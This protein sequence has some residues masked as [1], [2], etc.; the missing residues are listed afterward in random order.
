MNLYVHVKDSLE[1]VYRCTNR[2]LPNGN[3]TFI[4]NFGTLFP[5][6]KL[7][8]IMG[9]YTID[10]NADYL[11]VI[12][13]TRDT[14]NINTFHLM[15]T[16]NANGS[17]VVWQECS[18]P[19]NDGTYV[20]GLTIDNHNPSIVYLTYGNPKNDLGEPMEGL[21]Y[22]LDYTASVSNPVVTDLTKNLPYTYI[23][24]NS[25]T[26]EKSLNNG[27]YLATEFGVFYTDDILLAETDWSWKLVGKNLPHTG[28]NGIEINY[29]SNTIRVGTWGRGVWDIPLPCLTTPTSLQI[30]TNTII[31]SDIR[32]DRDIIVKSGKTLTIT[33][34]AHVY[35]PESGKIIVEPG[36]KLYV[37]NGTITSGCQGMWE[38]VQVWG[39]SNNHQWPDSHGNF[40]QGYVS[41]EDAT[42]SNAKFALNLYN[43]A[44]RAS[45]GGIVIANNSHFL[46]N[47]QSVHILNYRNF[48]PVTGVEMDYQAIFSNCD[49]RI[50]GEYWGTYEFFKHVDL[51]NVRGIKFKGSDFY[52]DPEATNVNKF[53]HGIAAYSAGFT[54]GPMCAS[55]IDP[56]PAYDKCTFSGLRSGITVRNTNSTNTFAVSESIF[57]NLVYGI[58]NYSANNATIVNN[59]FNIGSSYCEDQCAFGIYQR[60]AHGFGIENNTFSLYQN[61]NCIDHYGIC[62]MNTNAIDEIYHN[63]FTNLKYANF[64]QGKNHRL[65]QNNEG[66]KYFCN[67]NKSNYADFYVQPNL[68]SAVQYSQ[69]SPILP[70]GNTFSRAAVYHLYSGLSHMA[71]YYYMNP[72][73]TPDT[74]KINQ[75]VV[76]IPVSVANQCANHYGGTIKDVRLTPSEEELTEIDYADALYNFNQINTLYNSLIAG[77]STDTKLTEVNTATLDDAW[78][79]RTNLLGTSPHLSETVLKAM[80]DRTDILSDQTMFEILSANPDELRNNELMKYLEEKSTPLPQFMIDILKQMSSGISYRTTLEMNLAYYE[81]LKTRAANDMIRSLL[82]EE[83]IDYNELRNWL[84][85]LGGIEADR[86]IISTYVQEKN[87]PEAITLANLLP[88]L[89]NFSTEEQEVYDDYLYMLNLQQT[90]HQQDRTIEELTEVELS[91]VQSISS[92]IEELGGIQAK[93]VMEAVFDDWFWNCP[94]V[95]DTAT[96]RHSSIDPGQ[97]TKAMG[98]EISVSPNPAKEW[99]AIDY[100]LPDKESSANL[101]ILDSKNAIVKTIKVNGQQGEYVW[102]CSTFP[103]GTYYYTFSV[104]KI[105]LSGKIIIIK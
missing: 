36:A 31:D 79:L 40:A 6:N 24:D 12:L 30:Q 44:N 43:P 99:V 8:L 47:T 52:L 82:N 98:I 87:F 73:Q 48:H 81:R 88:S 65:N 14:A 34:G 103:A 61:S 62:T 19:R 38:G 15:R 57:E 20:V 96:L 23:R 85:N 50:D 27:I 95:N 37:N 51:L 55:Q 56:C 101:I 89:Y 13:L 28:A 5:G 64:A 91:N 21:V 59:V 10:N 67:Q 11:Y 26:L 66:L 18:L 71:Y 7:N 63:S 83:S 105:V 77:G 68:T 53:N 72:W 2:G 33:N 25:I 102:N 78:A 90:L 97:L 70:T 29:P 86:Q 22:K 58:D 80:A 75:L 74:T 93:G 39:N 32:Y 49:F 42:I 16:M 4:S 41:L 84:D 104:G 76:A 60:L 45:S 69:G 17:S 100:K 9:L 54:V 1:E 35:M 94:D 92:N 3:N 46:N